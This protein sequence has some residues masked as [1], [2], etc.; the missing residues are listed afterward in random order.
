MNKYVNDECLRDSH[1]LKYFTDDGEKATFY[2]I[3]CNKTKK[4][5]YA[6]K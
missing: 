3:D 2:C 5:T 6:I 1:N 4:I